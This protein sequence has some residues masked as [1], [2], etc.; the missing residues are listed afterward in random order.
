MYVC[1][2]LTLQLLS[3]P[4]QTGLI[5]LNAEAIAKKKC[6][7]ATDKKKRG[8]YSSYQCIRYP[9]LQIVLITTILHSIFC[10]PG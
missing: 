3:F 9:G 5:G 8:G 10:Y 1:F 4:M 2:L 6:G 7:I